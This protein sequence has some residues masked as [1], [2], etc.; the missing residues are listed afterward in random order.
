MSGRDYPVN[1]PQKF[2]DGHDLIDTAFDPYI[3]QFKE[4]IILHSIPLQSRYRWSGVYINTL[5][6]SWLRYGH[7]LSLQAIQDACKYAIHVAKKG[8]RE[9]LEKIG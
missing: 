6:K 8:L 2:E 7:L 4:E 1:W 3:V 9:Q 5:F